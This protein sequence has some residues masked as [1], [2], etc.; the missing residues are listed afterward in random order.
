VTS[1]INET[2]EIATK[3]YVYDHF[4]TSTDVGYILIDMRTKEEYLGGHIPGAIN[5]PYAECFNAD[6]TVLNFKDLK[7]LLVSHGIAVDK[8]M[9][10][11]SNK[12]Y[13]GCFFYFL[14]RLM[15][16]SN[17]TSYIG[18]IEDWVAANPDAYPLVTGSS[19]Y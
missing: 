14:C 4:F 1:Q 7:S 12:G 19:P 8:E 3:A 13:R 18:S 15:G 17:I 2:V 6:K 10:V 16:Y 11:Y 5:F 9:V